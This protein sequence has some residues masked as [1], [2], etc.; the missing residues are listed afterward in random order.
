[1]VELLTPVRSSKIFST[2]A[3][4]GTR[5]TELQ[6]IQFEWENV[7]WAQASESFAR[8][9]NA[10]NKNDHSG[11]NAVGAAVSIRDTA[12]KHDQLAVLHQFDAT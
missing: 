9:V 10:T 12:Q 3:P 7:K 4:A 5:L 1:M 6:R 11:S 2:T 8:N